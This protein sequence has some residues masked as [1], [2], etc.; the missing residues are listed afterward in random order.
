MSDEC[1]GAGRCHG[2]LGWCDNCG[3]VARVC[4]ARE[5][6]S[7]QPCECGRRCTSHESAEGGVCEYC[8]PAVALQQAVAFLSGGCLC[9]WDGRYRCP[10]HKT[11]RA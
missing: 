10:M 9:E 1:P 3:D 8:E 6:D 11:V 2:C 4:D 7:H 5:C